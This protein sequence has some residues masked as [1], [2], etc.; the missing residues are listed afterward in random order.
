MVPH[1][2]VGQQQVAD[3]QMA[4]EDRAAV[5]G[6]SGAVDRLLRS[7]ASS[8]ASPTGPILPWSVESKVEQ[9]L[10]KKR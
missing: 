7:S 2:R 10:K 8:S 6:E 9:Y 4:E 5:L 3:E 1:V